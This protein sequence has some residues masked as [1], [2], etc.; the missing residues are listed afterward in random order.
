MIINNRL[1][2]IVVLGLII[3]MAACSSKEDSHTR[4]VTISAAASLKKPLEILEEQYEK[5]NPTIELY[6]NYGGSGALKNQILQGAPVDVYIS[7]NKRNV[8]ELID[9]GKMKQD[10]I[11]ELLSNQLVIIMSENKEE[12]TTLNG[13]AESDM[14]FAIGNPDTVPAGMYAKESLTALNLW[15]PLKK[16]FVYA[17]DVRHVLSLV[18]Q[19]SVI[20]GI[21]YQSDAQSSNKVKVI[22]RMNPD[23]YS[24]ITYSIG[25]IDDSSYKNLGSNFV[26]FLSSSEAQEVFENAGFVP[27]N[28]K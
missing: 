13:I 12:V 14:K 5:E 11:V 10:A 22:N 28:I 23:T 21:V 6:F 17:K 19:G 15:E 20:G 24:R 8:Q 9:E 7:A 4:E 2:M 3:L 27:L 18:E 26:S 16:Q 25:V 1:K